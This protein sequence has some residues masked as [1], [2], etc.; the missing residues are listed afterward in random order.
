MSE[1]GPPIVATEVTLATAGMEPVFATV[2]EN[3]ELAGAELMMSG[4][5]NVTDILSAAMSPALA[6]EIWQP[7]VPTLMFWTAET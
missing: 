7:N 3:G 6:E 5:L 4:A 1:K 2:K